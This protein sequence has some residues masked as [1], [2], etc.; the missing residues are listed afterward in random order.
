MS[1]I[2]PLALSEALIR[3]PSITP[4]DAGALNVLEEALT[5]IG[6]TCHRLSFTKVGTPD[7]ENLY[8]RIGTG[9]LNFCFAGHTDVVPI[10]DRDD[11]SVDPFGGQVREGVLYGRGA[12]DMKCAIACFA[13]AAARFLE[14]HGNEFD[15]SI[16]FLITGDE[17]G[18]AINGTQRV[19]DWMGDEDETIDACLVGEPTSV[20]VLGDTI[21]IGR[22]GSMNGHLTVYGTQG[23]SAYPHLADNPV[24]VMVKMLNALD[25]EHLDD[26]SEH[27]PQSNLEIVTIDVGNPATNVIPAK[28]EASFNIRLN[29]GHMGVG[30]EQRM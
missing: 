20:D 18:P 15:G 27:F 7:V 4:E 2:D 16:S 21:K 24:P 19:L 22:R 25:G 14:R 30:L 23:H 6:F 11:W 12:S 1:T 5:D 29:D 8:A 26:G 10:G 28:I 13:A 9:G 17:E 3:C